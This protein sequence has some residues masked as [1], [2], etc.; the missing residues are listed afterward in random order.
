MNRIQEVLKEQGRSQTWL[1]EQ[2]NKSYN[3]VNSYVK[4]RRQPSLDI[5][6]RI[7][8]ILAVDA[9]QLLLSNLEDQMTTTGEVV[10]VPILGTAS[11]GKPILSIEDKEGDI[12]ISTK[13]LKKGEHYFI[14]R[15]SGNSMNKANI[16]DGDMVLI[17]QQQTASS[18][19]VIVALID[20]E[21]TIKELHQKDDLVILKPNSTEK[22][23][24]PIILTS[25]FKI[26]G[27]VERVINF[28]K[29]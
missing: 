19:D 22:N 3:M 24:Q 10:N 13:L 23:H 27:L 17:R 1:A 14:L 2:L 15:A 7:A 21:A 18:K 25:D 8:D 4:N 29:Y 16:N 9:R 6:Y 26:Q 28:K 12:P 5:L 11:C 20:N